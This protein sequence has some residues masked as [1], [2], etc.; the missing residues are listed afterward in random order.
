MNVNSPD[1]KTIENVPYSFSFFSNNDLGSLGVVYRVNGLM[2]QS[3]ML[4]TTN[5]LETLVGYPATGLP[6]EATTSGTLF[7]IVAKATKV[8]NKIMAGFHVRAPKSVS[9]DLGRFNRIQQEKSLLLASNFIGSK[10]SKLHCYQ[11]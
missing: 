6:G 7:S 8:Q 1:L 11:G 9:N 4:S 3:K 5:L 2:L 10:M